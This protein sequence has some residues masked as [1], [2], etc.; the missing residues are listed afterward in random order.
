MT[1]D[2]VL[3]GDDILPL[4]IVAHNEMVGLSSKFQYKKMIQTLARRFKIFREI[5]LFCVEK[6]QHLA[7]G[8]CEWNIGECNPI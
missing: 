2:R 4:S 8:I 5:I 7:C 3:F 1:F 6:K